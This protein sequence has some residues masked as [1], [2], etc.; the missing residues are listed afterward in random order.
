MLK[1]WAITYIKSRDIILRRISAIEDKGDYFLV[2]HKDESHVVVIVRD[3]LSGFAELM[4]RIQELEKLHR[5]NKVTVII[6]NNELNFKHL[7]T[8]WSEL[9][10]HSLLTII[11]ANPALNEKWSISPTI[12]HK[13]ADPLSLKQGLR[14]IFE[15]VPCV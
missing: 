11:F 4:P 1:D 2:S 5:A 9:I 12:H 3:V 7:V 15:S 10:Q 13:I 6:Y 14:A 8:A